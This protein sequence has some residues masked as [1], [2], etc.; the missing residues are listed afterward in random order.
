M[1]SFTGGPASGLKLLL[2]RSP[3]FLRV[4]ELDGKWDAC[5]Q[6]NDTPAPNEKIY[7]YELEDE[8]GRCHLYFGGGKG[9]WYAIADYLFLSDQ[10]CDADMRDTARWQA[11]CRRTAKSLGPVAWANK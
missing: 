9:G 11:W 8:P 3:R 6:L 1:T 4:V 5:D 2:H 7:A 10:P